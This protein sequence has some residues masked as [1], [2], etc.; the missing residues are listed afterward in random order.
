MKS[1][2][3]FSLEVNLVLCNRQQEPNPRPFPEELPSS[4][5]HHLRWNAPGKPHFRLQNRIPNCKFEDTIPE[6]SQ[7]LLAL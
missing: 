7:D 1:D 2:C 5:K 4:I 6:G 3:Q